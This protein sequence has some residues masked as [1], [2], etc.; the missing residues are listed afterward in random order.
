MRRVRNVKCADCKD[1]FKI[2]YDSRK[3]RQDTYSCKCGKLRCRPDSYGGFSYG[4]D[5]NYEEMSY[6]EEERVISYYEEDYIQLSDEAKQLIS[7]I[8]KLGKDL[9]DNTIGVYFYDYT[10]DEKISFELD[11]GSDL[12]GLSI[13]SKV[14]LR[15]DQGWRWDREKQENRVIESLTRFKDILIK[16]QNKELDLSKPRK[17]WDNDSLE[18][19]DGTRIQQKLY[20]YELYC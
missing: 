7:E 17:V 9:A 18:W 16:V 4:R 20:D 13:E 12:E 1:V 5:G 14:T 2:E 11:G 3:D 6:E 8:S 10:C 15:D 19:H